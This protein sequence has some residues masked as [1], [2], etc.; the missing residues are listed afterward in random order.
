MSIQFINFENIF[1]GDL[2]HDL[3]LYIKYYKGYCILSEEPKINILNTFQLSAN[4]L[5]VHPSKVEDEIFFNER[6]SPSFDYFRNFKKVLT[7]QPENEFFSLNRLEQ[8]YFWFHEEE[9][10]FEQLKKHQN[11]ALHSTQRIYSRHQKDALKKVF[12]EAANKQKKYHE[13]LDKELERVLSRGGKREGA[14]RP[15]KEPT[16]PIRL[17]DEKNLRKLNEFLDKKLTN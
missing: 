4:F 2:N 8:L 6:Y 10:F 9:C 3:D 13:H 14:G 12:D 5:N 16:K 17:I 1:T 7:L 15:A 11:H